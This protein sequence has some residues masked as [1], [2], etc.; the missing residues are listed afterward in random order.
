[1]LLKHCIV[2]VII[3]YIVKIKSKVIVIRGRNALFY[4][5]IAK[6]TLTA[7]LN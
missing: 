4:N 7:T 2:I 6:L 3:I 1:M 5:I